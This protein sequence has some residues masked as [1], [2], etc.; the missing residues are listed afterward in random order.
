MFE[1]IQ[2]KVITLSSLSFFLKN[3]VFRK[4]SSINRKNGRKIRENID[5]IETF[6][7][8]TTIDKIDKD[9]IHFCVAWK[10]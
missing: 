7:K 4:V 10:V 2:G 6:G 1:I 9:L 8:R 3:K 5:Y